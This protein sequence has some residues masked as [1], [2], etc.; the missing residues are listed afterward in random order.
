MQVAADRKISF[1]ARIPFL[2]LSQATVCERV[3][4]GTFMQ[5]RLLSARSNIRLSDCVA[6]TGRPYVISVHLDDNA[7]PLTSP[8]MIQIVVTFGSCI[9]L[10]GTKSAPLNVTGILNFSQ[11]TGIPSSADYCCC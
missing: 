5:S 11:L 3:V 9:P 1:E 6:S 8:R 7:P 4:G 2:S 10:N